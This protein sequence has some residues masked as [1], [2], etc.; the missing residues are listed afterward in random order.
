[1]TRGTNNKIHREYA[2]E[3]IRKN[4][5]PDKPSRLTSAYVCPTIEE[6]I[7][8]WQET[9]QSGIIY[10]V[11]FVEPDP[12]FHFGDWKKI[13]PD[14]DLW[15][16]NIN[17]IAND[18]WQGKEIENPEIVVASPLRVLRMMTKDGFITIS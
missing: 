18:Y 16:E 2:L 13:N 15:L 12:A 11:E 14:G 4:K 1:M 7:K 6:M 9:N 3:E 17:Q 10:E 5:Y 8:F